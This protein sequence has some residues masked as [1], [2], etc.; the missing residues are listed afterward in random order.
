MVNM[1]L[2][3]AK[4]AY[5]DIRDMQE[6]FGVGRT[7]IWRHETG[8]IRGFPRSMRILGKRQ[9]EKKAVLDYIAGLEKAS[10]KAT[11]IM[12]RHQMMV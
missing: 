9:W 8:C 1:K 7:T 5:L 2:L 4:G 6:V 3:E 12:S 11:S 10:Q